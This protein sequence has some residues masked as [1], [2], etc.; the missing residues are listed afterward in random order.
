MKIVPES[1]PTAASETS[2]SA[3]IWDATGP[4]L[5]PFHAPLNP[6]MATA[7]ITR[8]VG[9]TAGNAASLAHSPGGEHIGAR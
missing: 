6:T 9:R 8:G 5:P 7:A 1:S 4:T 3:P 2:N